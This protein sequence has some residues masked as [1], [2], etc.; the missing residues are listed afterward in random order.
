MHISQ[1]FRQ[2]LF[3]SF[4]KIKQK[5]GVLYLV[6]IILAL[7]A[8]EAFNYSTTDFAL[9]DL[10]GDLRFVGIRWAT[11]LSLAFS[12]IDFAGIARLFTPETEENEPKAVW[13]LFG[14]WILAA[15]MNAI[16]TWWGV[17]MAMQ[18]HPVLSAGMVDA[19]FISKV[20]PIFIAVMVWLIRILII[21]TLS[22]RGDHLLH[23]ADRPELQPV[24]RRE[25]RQAQ[26]RAAHPETSRL[27]AQKP[28][29]AVSVQQRPERT[30]RPSRPEPNY[31]P[32]QEEAVYRTL[33]ASGAKRQA[34]R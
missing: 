4:V 34:R 30:K 29:R 7:I 8:F 17:L 24:S 16:L 26:S 23:G 9:S 5:K 6:I 1:S 31:I 15:T 10:L 20:V 3:K 18:T 27:P 11:I 12:G 28:A 13:Y 32:L 25:Y 22:S 2:N 19:V 14:A 21:G 33:Q